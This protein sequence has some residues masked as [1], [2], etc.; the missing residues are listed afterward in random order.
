MERKPLVGARQRCGWWGVGVAGAYMDCTMVGK[1][2]LN[3]QAEMCRFCIRQNS[4]V[5]GSRQACFSP[6]QVEPRAAWPTVSRS[7]R[8]TARARS[9]GVSQR[10]WEGSSGRRM[11]PKMATRAVIEPSMMKSLGVGVSWWF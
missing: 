4:H 3:E 1:K 9:A 7:M 6:S 10:V 8:A 2:L 11:K 5:R